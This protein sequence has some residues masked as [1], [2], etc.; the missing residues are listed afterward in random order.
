MQL[1]FSKW[2]QSAAKNVVLKK[3]RNL[4]LVNSLE[5]VVLAVPGIIWLIIFCYLPMGGLIIAFKDFNYRDGIL[6]S[7]WV[8]L[9]NF[10]YLFQSMDAYRII[11]NTFLYNLMFII[12]GTIVAVLVALLLDSL[13]S[14]MHLKIFQT[15]YFLP[16][17]LSWVVVGFISSILLNPAL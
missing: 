4:G 3:K 6:G 11:R 16:Y 15:C 5:L 17:F 2:H 12:V 7:P 10:Q 14:K 9:Q 1:N 13:R 8:G